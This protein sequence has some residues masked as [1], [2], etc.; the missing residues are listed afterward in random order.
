M[1]RGEAGTGFPANSE[2]HGAEKVN[3]F[4]GRKLRM[5]SIQAAARQS[6][7]REN[8]EMR[9]GNGELAQ[10][11]EVQ[12]LGERRRMWDCQGSETQIPDS[13]E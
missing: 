13:R 7:N 8:C 1:L 5:Y 4:S 11:V 6:G 3:I 12:E 9:T 10:K 2:T